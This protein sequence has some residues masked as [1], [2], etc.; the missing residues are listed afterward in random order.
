LT[1]LKLLI[2]APC[3]NH[4][5]AVIVIA[6]LRA[7]QL[8]QPEQRL[9]GHLGVEAGR[10]R[11]LGSVTC[12]PGPL[13][14]NYRVRAP[15]EDWQDVSEAVPIRRNQIFGAERPRGYLGRRGGLARMVMVYRLPE[16]DWFQP[17]TLQH[18]VQ[19]SDGEVSAATTCGALGQ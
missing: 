7:T 19:F 3:Q 11:R 14:P 15:G 6:V 1:W 10:T 13:H 4:C 9:V 12:R 8:L 2:T 17:V 16:I 5:D 18:T